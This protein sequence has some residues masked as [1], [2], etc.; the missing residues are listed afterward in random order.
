MA[1]WIDCAVL[2]HP[3][4]LEGGLVCRAAAGLPLLLSEGAECALVPP[5]LDVP[6]TVT[7]GRLEPRPK[8]GEAVVYFR[9]VADASVAQALAGC[10]CLMRADQVDAEAV[11][12]AVASD[13]LACEGYQVVDSAAGPVGAVAGVDEAP[14][15][16]RLVVERPEG[17]RPLLVPI[18]PEIVAGVDDER[19]T[20]DVR[21]PA[22]LLEL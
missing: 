12:A 6:R 1:D 14:G 13:A 7:V 10:H 18:V 16:M 3:K 19:R 20:V 22:G 9:E 4:G 5:Q 15:Q 2:A 8:A 21:L 11:V 17:G